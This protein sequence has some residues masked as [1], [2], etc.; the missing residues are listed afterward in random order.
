VL[1]NVSDVPGV[2][3]LL[4]AQHELVVGGLTVLA[5]VE[6]PS[7]QIGSSKRYLLHF[8]LGISGQLGFLSKNHPVASGITNPGNH[9]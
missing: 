7:L 4:S 2:V 8:Q 5:Q 3:S 9:N 6:G 1:Q